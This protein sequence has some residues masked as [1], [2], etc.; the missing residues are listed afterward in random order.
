MQAEENT[1]GD[2]V[3]FLVESE[4]RDAPGMQWTGGHKVQ[5]GATVWQCFVIK[6]SEVQAA[7]LAFDGIWQASSLTHQRVFNRGGL[8]ECF[9][10]LHMSAFPGFLQPRVGAYSCIN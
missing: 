9:C 7:K 4:V 5:H 8:E 6:G 1:H 10:S 3:G 2:L